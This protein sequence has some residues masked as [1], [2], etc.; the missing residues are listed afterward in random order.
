MNP[1][2]AFAIRSPLRLSPARERWVYAIGL[3]TW[4]SGAAWLAVRYFARV[5]GLP[6]PLE[7]WLIR[8]HSAFAFGALWMC[9]VVWAAHVQPS[10]EQLARRRSGIALA[11]VLVVLVVSAYGLFYLGNERA[12]AIASVLHWGIGLALPGWLLIHVVGQR[13]RRARA[14]S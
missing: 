8:A 5:E 12:R 7:P 1:R 3:G 2:E 4:V 9:G 13:R 6:H 10:W 11:A 14:R